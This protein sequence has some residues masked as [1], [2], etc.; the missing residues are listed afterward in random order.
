MSAIY[1]CAVMNTKLRIIDGMI[2]ISKGDKS[3]M[4][5]KLTNQ[6][7][8]LNK[9]IVTAGCH[10]IDKTTTQSFK[11]ILLDNTMYHYCTY[12]QYLYYLDNASK[13]SL[14]TFYKNSPQL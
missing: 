3:N 6:S 8:V 10:P 1:S 13:A 5:Q 11:K 14:G 12:R 7:N 4:I 9:Q 2:K